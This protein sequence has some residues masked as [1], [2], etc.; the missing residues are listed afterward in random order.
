M[1]KRAEFGREN[2]KT[3]SSEPSGN[4]GAKQRR[5]LEAIGFS[6]IVPI[7]IITTYALSGIFGC[8]SEETGPESFASFKQA[9]RATRSDDVEL[10]FVQRR[11][12]LD[13]EIILSEIEGTMT[14]EIRQRVA[15]P[16]S[17][18]DDPFIYDEQASY[19]TDEDGTLHSTYV[20]WK[21]PNP[22]FGA[23]SVLPVHPLTIDPELTRELEEIRAGV[24]EDF[25]SRDGL[26]QGGPRVE[27]PIGTR[28]H[29]RGQRDLRQAGRFSATSI[30]RSR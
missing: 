7:I 12:Q 10:L 25:G 23:P 18:S 19:W 13:G 30:R 4:E 27:H 22:L 1:P 9:L 20:V 8:S 3:A 14:E 29:L 16:Y 24:R 26:A 28:C 2:G 17:Y 21:K 15:R 6:R 11:A 5:T